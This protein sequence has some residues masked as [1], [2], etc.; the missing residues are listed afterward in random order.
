[1]LVGIKVWS[2]AFSLI[3]VSRD[4]ESVRAVVVSRD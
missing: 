1:M 3:A 4:V 2:F